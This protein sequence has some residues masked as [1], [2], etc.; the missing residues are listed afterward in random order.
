MNE[1]FGVSHQLDVG[2]ADRIEDD[3]VQ[4]TFTRDFG[5]LPGGTTLTS[6]RP[7]P[8]TA[9]PSCPLTPTTAEV[10]ATDAH[11]RPALLRRR[12]AAAR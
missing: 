9:A 7:A 4:L 2:I 12:S 6:R 1:L 11:G 8:S 10:I 3:I 5:G